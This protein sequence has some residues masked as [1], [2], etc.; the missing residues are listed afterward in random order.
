MRKAIRRERTSTSRACQHHCWIKT[1][2]VRHPHTVEHKAEAVAVGMICPSV[3]PK[4][5]HKVTLRLEGEHQLT[6]GKVRG[7]AEHHEETL[8]QSQALTE[9]RT[10]KLRGHCATE[11]RRRMHRSSPALSH[12]GSKSISRWERIK[13][14]LFAGTESTGKPVRLCPNAQTGLGEHPAGTQEEHLQTLNFP[15]PKASYAAI[16]KMEK[17]LVRH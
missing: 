16:R 6:G 17:T 12:R 11:M 3:D 9:P 7:V 1:L 13:Q 8:P 4:F 14:N 15:K 2:T 5:K 10:V